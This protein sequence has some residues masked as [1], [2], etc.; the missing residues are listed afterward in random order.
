MLIGLFTM[1]IYGETSATIS[2][3]ETENKRK[4][5]PADFEPNT[6][7]LYKLGK[8]Y[9][10]HDFAFYRLKWNEVCQSMAAFHQQYDMLLTPT[11][12][13]KPFKIGAI[14][15]SKL[16]NS[17]LKILNNLGISSILRHTK[18]VEKIAAKTFNWIPCA[19]LANITGQP[20]MSIPM[21]WSKENLPVGTMFTGKLNDEGTLFRLA[22]QL[23]KAKPW[24]DNVPKL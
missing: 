23:E 18:E 13:M 16:E 12:G 7:L 20:S 21:H 4:A 22:A 3:L 14:Q 9:S 1:M 2:Y 8:S 24:F 10:A 11:L 6:W 19:P 5:T 15:S 17:A